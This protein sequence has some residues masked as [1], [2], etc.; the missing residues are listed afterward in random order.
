MFVGRIQN[1]S[2]NVP[3]VLPVARFRVEM[4]RGGERRM[5]SLVCRVGIS[6]KCHKKYPPSPTHTHQTAQRELL[7][8]KPNAQET[9]FTISF[10]AVAMFSRFRFL[11]NVQRDFPRHY[12]QGREDESSKQTIVHIFVVVSPVVP[13]Y[14]DQ[15]NTDLLAY[16]VRARWTC[17]ISSRRDIR[18]HGEWNQ[19]SLPS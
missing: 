7:N 16:N 4:E 14:L 11:T 19:N 10:L 5:S 13:T 8:K 17:S 6:R 2:K 12:T 9:G 3:G 15:I 18:R 1:V